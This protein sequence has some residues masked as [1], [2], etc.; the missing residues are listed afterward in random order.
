LKHARYQKV[1]NG[2]LRRLGR[3]QKNMSRKQK[4]E[5]EREGKGEEE[6][7]GKDERKGGGRKEGRKFIEPIL[8][9][10]QAINNLTPLD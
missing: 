7:A 9:L 6:L 1:S 4:G 10:A 2:H 5:Q 3:Y 8:I